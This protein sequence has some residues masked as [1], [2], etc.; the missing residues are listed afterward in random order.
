MKNVISPKFLPKAYA[1]NKEE[2][3]L[4]TI[5]SNYGF[6]N[7]FLDQKFIDS[8]YEK[9]S[10]IQKTVGNVKNNLKVKRDDLLGKIADLKSQGY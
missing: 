7:N 9:L 6:K 1:E 3:F 4:I 5:F 2:N 8:Q 10:D